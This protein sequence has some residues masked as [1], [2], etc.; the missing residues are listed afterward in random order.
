MGQ[1]ANSTNRE[2]TL[3]RRIQIIGSTNAGKTT[4][5]RRLFREYSLPF[6]ELDALIPMN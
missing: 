2:K 6:I 1:K 3:N 4:L 5:G